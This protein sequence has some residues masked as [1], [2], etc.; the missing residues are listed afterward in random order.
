MA[1][2][3]S[4]CVVEKVLD[5]REV[6]VEVTDDEA[7]A[8]EEEER[9]EGEGEG[10]AQEPA[11]SPEELQKELAVARAARVLPTDS[12]PPS[13]QGWFKW[14]RCRYVF[15]RIA[16]DEYADWFAD[17]V[18]TSIYPDYLNIV[19]RGMCLAEVRAELEKEEPYKNKLALFDAD[20]WLIWKNCQRYYPV[21]SAVYQAGEV[22][23]RIFDR[24]LNA[25]V[26]NFKSGLHKWEDAPSRPWETFCLTC[27]STRPDK[28]PE[29][30]TCDF[31]EGQYHIGCL[32]PP[33]VDVPAGPWLCQGCE[34][35]ER[36]GAIGHH[37]HLLEEALREKVARQCHTTTLK[38]QKMYL[39][40]WKDLSNA[41][42]TWE[43]P[44]DLQDNARAP[45]TTSSTTRPPKSRPCRRRPS[46][47]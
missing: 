44:E 3:C 4:C 31:C 19:E 42:C 40:K 18:D 8:D 23:S 7:G 16:Q 20:M 21:Q 47:R 11:S 33:L 5:C 17:P 9:G 1:P 12:L 22:L 29:L 27:T 25:W 43:K 41:S 36:E 34:Q 45:S 26:L 37:S 39:V 30:M 28:E 15:N 13:G 6:E 10:G 2:G 24:L 35:I 32:E 46:S 14:M 38:K